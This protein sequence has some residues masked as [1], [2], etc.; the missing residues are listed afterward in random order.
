MI[1]VPFNKEETKLS[2]SIRSSS[3]S[4]EEWIA[5]L[6]S[7]VASLS[8]LSCFFFFFYLGFPIIPLF[9]FL[10]FFFYFFTSIFN[11]S[12]PLDFCFCFFL[13][14][15][16]LFHSLYLCVCFISVLPGRTKRDC[17]RYA[18]ACNSGAYVNLSFFFVFMLL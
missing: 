5:K 3:V 16:S 11:L 14:I 7:Y 18:Q 2:E 13:Y 4:N 12:V 6:A 10:R 1:H 15:F 8:L 9:S 17:E